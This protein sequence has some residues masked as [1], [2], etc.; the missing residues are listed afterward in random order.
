MRPDWYDEAS[1][2]EKFLQFFL[3]LMPEGLVHE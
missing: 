1:L 2:K 3:L